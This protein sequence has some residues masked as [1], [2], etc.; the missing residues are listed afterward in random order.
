MA[1]KYNLIF[2]TAKSKSFYFSLLWQGVWDIAFLASDLRLSDLK[3]V[4]LFEEQN[5]S[6]FHRRA[7]RTRSGGR[8]MRS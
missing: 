4:I 8:R 2:G 7:L 5:R 1:I 6:I 3:E